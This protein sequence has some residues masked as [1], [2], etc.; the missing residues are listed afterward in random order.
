MTDENMSLITVW[1]CTVIAAD[2]TYTFKSNEH[3]ASESQH[4][5][6]ISEHCS[7]VSPYLLHGY[8]NRTVYETHLAILSNVES[9]M[10]LS[11][12]SSE[13]S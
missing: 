7:V 12:S 5:T 10:L 1:Y 6:Q 3:E 13:Y 11:V 9:A 4:G 2:W 8:A